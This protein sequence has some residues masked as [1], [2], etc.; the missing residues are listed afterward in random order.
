MTSSQI[1]AVLGAR[2]QIIF[3]VVVICALIGFGVSA[4][5]PHKYTATASV[6]VDAKGVDP[7][8]GVERVQVANLTIIATQVDLL[9][10]GRVARAV[11]DTL[12]LG[13]NPEFVGQ[14]IDETGGKG[15]KTSFIATQLLKGLE[16]RPNRDSSVIGISYTN[17]NPKLASDIANAFARSHIAVSLE[18]KV[19]P[20]RQFAGWFD[21]RT[22]RL[23][24]AIEAA[25]SRLA[26]YQRDSGMISTGQGQID[27]ENSKLIGLN[28][29]L[30]EIQAARAE[31]ASRR[32]QANR[33]AGVSADV[34]NS[35]V[36]ESL[37]EEVA[38]SEVALRRLL[39]QFGANH[40]D[41]I[42]ATDQ[43][44]SLIAQLRS[45]MSRVASSVSSTNT[46][47]ERREA[48]VRGAVDAQR[49]RLLDLTSKS[50]EMSVLTRDVENAQR[51]YEAA[52]TR[53]S[54]TA[55]ES[56]VQQTNVYLVTS[57]TEPPMPSSP[58]I[59]LNTLFAAM[60]G[61]LLGMGVALLKEARVPVVRSTFD[62][63]AA[64]GLPLLAVVSRARQTP[65]F[66]SP[67]L[68]SVSALRLKGRAA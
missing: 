7:I 57:A 19:D 21:E 51:A 10:S 66:G 56:Q 41:V 63:A 32:A 37:R 54:Q 8:G 9:T 26:A 60:L 16:V 42:R 31:S 44:A 40:P 15:D 22:K 12:H 11:V 53:S 38:K 6:L 20:A 1:I 17:G 50:S 65:G 24:E 13:D 49:K 62:L 39:T 29:Q 45:E 4:A 25:Q 43:R 59:K 23:R 58:R 48:D 28:Q 3:S 18:L 2:W 64:T 35:P 14:W 34:I 55:L 47:N 5:W 46:V 27:A 67:L 52:A 61:L 33:D 36:I 68:P 30:I